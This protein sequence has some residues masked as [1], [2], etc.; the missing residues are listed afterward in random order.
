MRISLFTKTILIS[1]LV[2]LAACGHRSSADIKNY[3]AANA[4][5]ASTSC[6]PASSI[7]VTEG[8][9]AEAHDVVGDITATVSQWTVFDDTPTPA[10]LQDALREK[11][12]EVCA[13]AVISARFGTAGMSFTSWGAMEANGRAVKLAPAQ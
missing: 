6:R 4:T 13:D 1:S 7:L 11:A 10:M 5:A 9:I 8:T 3:N 12:H 2:L